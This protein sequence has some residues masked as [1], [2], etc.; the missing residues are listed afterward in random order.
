MSFCV[1]CGKQLQQEYD[2]CPECGLKVD[3]GVGG[4]SFDSYS[5]NYKTCR[6]CG[7]RMPEDMFYCLSCGTTCGDDDYNFEKRNMRFSDTNPT[8]KRI[9]DTSEGT[10]RN[11]WV[12][13]VLCLLFGV[14]GIHRFYEGKKITGFI[15][16]FTFGLLGYGVFF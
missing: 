16:L 8:Q 14:F 15:Y 4:S 12:A 11:K 1:G 6:C 9:V 10:W 3:R 13:L 5:S 7:E 2:F